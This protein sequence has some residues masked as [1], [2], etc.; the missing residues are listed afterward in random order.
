VPRGRLVVGLETLQDRAEVGFA[1]ALWFKA[2]RE[3]AG[4]EVY[5]GHLSGVGIDDEEPGG[6]MLG[7]E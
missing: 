6:G 4:G 2:K 5:V 7:K 1:A 3:V